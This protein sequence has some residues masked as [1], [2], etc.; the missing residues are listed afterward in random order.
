MVC[1]IGAKSAIVCIEVKASKQPAEKP[2]ESDRS[3][4]AGIKVFSR[5]KERYTKDSRDNEAVM[6]S[7]NG[8][9]VAQ[10]PPMTVRWR[11]YGSPLS[12]LNRRI[13]MPTPKKKAYRKPA[14]A[15]VRLMPEERLMMCE[16]HYDGCK[17]LG[18]NG[19]GN[20]S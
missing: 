6:A 17:V 5:C 19:I 13:V 18:N 14:T 11:A 15:V 9:E 2:V 12:W 20:C 1:F 16:K 7:L 4:P 8:R 10:S 3:A